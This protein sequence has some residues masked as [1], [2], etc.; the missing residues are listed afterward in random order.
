M[1]YSN[2]Y[3]NWT[4]VQT[5]EAKLREEAKVVTYSDLIAIHEAAIAVLLEKR[6]AR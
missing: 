4:R 6:N 1:N 5:S 3:E 2:N